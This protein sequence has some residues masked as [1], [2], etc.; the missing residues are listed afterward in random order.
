MFERFTD[1]ARQVVVLAQAEA[2]ELGHDWVGT[3]HLLLGLVRLGHGVGPRALEASGISLGAVR[4]Q[5]EE[6]VPRA[7]QAP[8]GHIRFTPQAKKVLELSLREALQFGHRYIGSEHI[9]LGLL[10]E[11]QGVAAQALTRLGADLDGMRQQ[12]DRLLNGPGRGSGP[13]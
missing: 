5:V 1:R 10:G 12:V 7:E 6:M 3:E 2:R 11:G 13:N 4:Q 9:L 8:S